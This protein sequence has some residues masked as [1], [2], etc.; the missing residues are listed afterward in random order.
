M[1]KVP[2]RAARRTTLM[3]LSLTMGGIALTQCH[4][5]NRAFASSEAVS[6]DAQ[7]QSVGHD[8][9]EQRFSPL[10]Q[11]DKASIARLGLA[12][13]A[14]LPGEGGQEATPIVADGVLFTST[15]FSI[16]RAY[17]AA[18]GKP[19]W[20]YDPQI[21]S[22][23]PKACCTPA[24]RGVALYGG[25][26]FIGRFD[27]ML[28]ALDA[29]TGHPVW[30]VQTTD[31]AKPQSISGAPQIA[32][33]K[34][35]IGNGGAE[36]G[37][38]GYV[39]AYDVDTGKQAWRFYTVPGAKPDGAASDEPIR[40][41]AA[42]TWSGDGYLKWGGGGTVWDSMAY[43]PNLDLLYIGT[44]NGSPWNHGLRS[45]GKGDNLFL[46]SIVALRP[47]TGE[48][49]W[50]YQQ[51][52]GESWDFTATQHMI[53]A[54]LI[55][56]N[57]LRH[58]LMQ[59][60]KNGFF[61]VL[62]RT[63]GQLISA[64]KYVPVNWASKIDP[65]SGRP[66][67]NPD[68]RY[69]KTG[70]P[71]VATSGPSGG[72][73]WQPMAYNPRRRLV[74]IPAHVMPFVYS[75]TAE[76]G[77]APLSLSVGVD[78]ASGGSPPQPAAM[79]EAMKAMTGMLIAWDPVGQREV[80]RVAHS[81]PWNGGVMATA[82]DL[83][84]QGDSSQHFNAY[85]AGDG[86]L[87]WSAPVQ[88][89][90]V[91]APITYSIDG[92]QYVAVMAGFTG[93]FANSGGGFSF[94]PDDPRGPNRLLVF[95]LGGTATLPPKPREERTLDPQLQTALNAATVREGSGLYG[96]YCGRCHG[97]FAIAGANAPDLRYSNTLTAGFQE[98]VHDGALQDLGMV[99]FASVMSVDQI[100]AIRSYLLSRAREDARSGQAAP[101]SHR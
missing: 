88:T 79:R 60:P 71:F 100:E 90:I 99:S 83:V 17:D 65:H 95:R 30:S 80:W 96:R 52:P 5:D 75:A 29:K 68:A 7:W 84:F 94:R 28:V 56:K 44:G 26:V 18:S 61:Y 36:F 82:G 23:L 85:S 16:V 77:P 46:S 45:D 24:N 2:R 66:V 78:L 31:S 70:K 35:I 34:V 32:K 67:E 64:E 101:R 97:A 19:L 8:Q 49:V 1:G 21:Q 37:V 42:R 25:K 72:H 41:L 62:D 39:T 53:L 33:G 6:R 43:D 59:A 9:G 22:A 11:I 57:R 27:G 74:F 15:D 4:W 12:W 50:H 93:A 92:V 51:T 91:A 14:D 20:V 47:E 63:N 69:Y 86:R 76:A 10:A 13:Y 48:Y 89:G 38:R 73:N 3:A 55:I 54:D 58:V 40:R 81:G 98:V 87:L